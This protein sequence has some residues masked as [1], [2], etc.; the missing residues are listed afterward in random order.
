MPMTVEAP[1]HSHGSLENRLEG[2]VFQ[3]VPFL[4]P[5]THSLSLILSQTPLAVL[6]IP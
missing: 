4:L 5:H 2:A 1:L 3:A 6:S